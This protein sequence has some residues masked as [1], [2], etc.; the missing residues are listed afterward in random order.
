MSSSQ[1]SQVVSDAAPHN[2]LNMIQEAKDSLC[3][4]LDVTGIHAL[5][6]LGSGLG[7]AVDALENRQHVATSEIQHMPHST[8]EGH[9][10]VL[11]V[12]TIGS[13]KILMLQ[14]RVHT[15][16]GI[17]PWKTSLIVRVA[18]QLG[19]RCAILTNSAGAVNPDFA[20]GDLML[21]NDHLNLSGRNPLIGPHSN[22][23][24][25]RFP[26]MTNAYTPRL[27]GLAREAAQHLGVTLR[28]GVYAWNLGPSYETPAEV[29]M[30]A[31]LG[32][33]AVGMSTAP[34]AIVARQES[35]DILAMSCISNLA[36]GLSPTPL[37][38]EEVQAVAGPAA[39]KLGQLL[40]EIIRGGL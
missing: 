30:A 8:V 31:T 15:Y 18:S 24:G 20:P 27:Q 7:G 1:T 16:E 23:F 6:I 22:D 40:V 2:L 19:A 21:I 12:G 33:D 35:M 14:G 25:P 36:A 38:H 9:Q 11:H 28:E 39:E 13:R 26:D 4:K 3:N 29:R 10:G 17:P 37:T 5:C 32:A 34:E